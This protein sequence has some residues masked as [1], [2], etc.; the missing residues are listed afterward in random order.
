MNPYGRHLDR[1]RTLAKASGR[2]FELWTGDGRTPQRYTCSEHPGVAL[3]I[4]ELRDLDP[5]PTAYRYLCGPPPT[6]SRP[7][8]GGGST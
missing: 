6:T 4:A 7:E 5:D 1:A 8:G 3:T 2:R